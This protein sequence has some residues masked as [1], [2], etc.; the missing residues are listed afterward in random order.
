MQPV[1]PK[2]QSNLS[3]S[4][5]SLWSLVEASAISGDLIHWYIE[6]LRRRRA[7]ARP[8]PSPT[9]VSG[10][11]YRR[12]VA[13]EP[14]RENEVAALAHAHLTRGRDLYRELEKDLGELRRYRQYLPGRLIEVEV[15]LGRRT[16]ANALEELAAG[17][18]EIDAEHEPLD[19]DWLESYVVGVSSAA[20]S[21]CVSSTTNGNS[22]M[23]VFTNKADEIATRLDNWALCERVFTMEHSRWER[24]VVCT[25]FDIP[26]VMDEDEDED[27]VRVITGTMARFP[28]FHTTGWLILRSAKVIRA[29]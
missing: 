28:R 5:Y 29:S 12:L 3:A 18:V 20:T 9:N 8:R 2:L 23:A 6:T 7:I 21:R 22:N 25:G 26:K 4:Y 13:A 10:H 14:D 16:I 27:E 15:V 1:S 19:S 24:A 17:L 11:T